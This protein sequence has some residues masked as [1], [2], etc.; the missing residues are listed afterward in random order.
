ML[1]GVPIDII[2]NVSGWSLFIVTVILFARSLSRGALVTSGTLQSIVAA[3]DRSTEQL[4]ET[5]EGRLSELK[6]FYEARLDEREELIRE[7]RENFTKTL[8]M[9]DEYKKQLE[10]LVRQ[11]ETTENVL[12][13]FSQIVR[14]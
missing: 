1:D 5:Y 3:A 11:G 8:E 14:P 10:S 6:I 2:G 13:A 7:S 9:L 12:I 4:K